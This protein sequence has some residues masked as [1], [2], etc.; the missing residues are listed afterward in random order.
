MQGIPVF[1]T[2]QAEVDD[3]YEDLYNREKK[4]AL[5]ILYLLFADGVCPA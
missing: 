4:E 2:Y 3:S 1:K 5:L